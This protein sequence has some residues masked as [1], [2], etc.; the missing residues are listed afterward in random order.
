MGL[1]QSDKYFPT[2]SSPFSLYYIEVLKK[3]VAMNL[4][5]TRKRNAANN[6]REREIDPFL[7]QPPNGDAAN[8]PGTQPCVPLNKEPDLTMPRLLT[9]RYC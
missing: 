9:H 3:Q 4:T 1:I 8:L 5:V 2:L 7:I 6:L